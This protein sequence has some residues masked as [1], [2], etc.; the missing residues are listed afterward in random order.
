METYRNLGGN[1]NVSAYEIKDDSI[2]VQFKDGGTYLY[3]YQSAGREIIEKMK[4]LAM[5]GQGLNTFINRF[6]RELYSA[7]LAGRK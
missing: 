5:A 3:N 6:A 2:T 4:A 7:K 1:S